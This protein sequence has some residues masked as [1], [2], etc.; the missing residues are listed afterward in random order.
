MHSRTQ[1]DCLR[2]TLQYV[3]ESTDGDVDLSGVHLEVRRA[4]SQ[5]D[6]VEEYDGVKRRGRE[7][8]ARILVAALIFFPSLAAVVVAGYL[9]KSALGIDFFPGE[10]LFHGIYETFRER[11]AYSDGVDGSESGSSLSGDEGGIGYGDGSGG[12]SEGS[13]S[14]P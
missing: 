7:S 3:C 1:V 6:E 10:S 9:A 13:T 2:E 12:A 8:P 4:L 14:E 5:L 11:P